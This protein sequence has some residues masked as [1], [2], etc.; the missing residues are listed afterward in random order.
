MAFS[1]TCPKCSAKLKTATAIPLGR[2]VQCPKCKTSFAVSD[3][4]ME[5][6]ADT[7][8]GFPAPASKSAPA[9]V[10]RRAPAPPARDAEEVESPFGSLDAPAK[11]KRRDDD[12]EDETPRSRKRDDDDDRPKKRNVRDEDDDEIPKSRKRRDDDDE[13]ENRPRSRKRDDDDEDDKPKSRKRRNEDEENEDDRP[14]RR[15]RD[16]DDDDRP[17]SK[18]KKKK[19]G[20]KGL[21]I[22]LAI[23][24]VLTVGGIVFLCFWL[25]GGGF[26]PEMMAYMPADSERLIG[27]DVDEVMSIGFVKEL[28]KDGPPG[29]GK[30]MEIFKKAG[31]SVD[32][33]AKMLLSQGKAGTT[34]VIRF[35]KAIDKGK[36]SS[37]FNG[38]EQK[39]GDKTYYKT[40]AKFGTSSFYFIP[41][42]DLIVVVDRE[43]TLKTLLKKDDGKVVISENLQK[44][45]KKV[46]S[47]QF[48]MAGN[49]KDLPIDPNDNKVPADVK[50][51]MKSAKGFAMSVKASETALDIKVLVLCD[52]SEK[53]SKAADAASKNLKEKKD[54]HERD[55]NQQA[56][57]LGE[58]GKKAF[59]DFVQTLNVSSSGEML[60]VSGNLNYSPFKEKIKT[61]FKGGR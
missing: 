28:L 35:K 9:T 43:D 55:I 45:A 6:V 30:E 34:M 56:G 53:A 27:V 22:G 11:K 8:T 15:G 48:W 25:F 57:Q 37:A 47:G 46:S 29:A 18:K 23:G 31:L 38:K 40:E 60:E 52:S 58:D 41:K 59:L 49:S 51:A 19:K 14:R 16:D 44:L 2:S 1:L 42:D 50:E 24:G 5:E 13:E 32:D 26:D 20:N 39:E 7:K 36:I 21:M 61:F 10:S 12:D 3:E 17:R 54:E 4:N 33:I